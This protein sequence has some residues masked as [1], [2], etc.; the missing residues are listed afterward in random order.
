VDDLAQ[1]VYL[2]LLRVSSIET[3]RDPLAYVLGVA[4]HATSEFNLR[5]RRARVVFDSSV[6]EAA[7]EMQASAGS[8]QRVDGGSYF[9]QNV[10]HALNRLSEKQL[11][12]LL[13]ERRN[14]LS[15]A[16]IAEELGLS[17]HTVKKYAVQALAL[18]RASFL[19][20]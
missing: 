6:F 5:K 3:I 10:T 17:V 4:A 7:L 8:Q 19:E 13:L 11:A 12:V 1:E 2:R 15:H 20:K 9:L 18:V 14:G 16:Q